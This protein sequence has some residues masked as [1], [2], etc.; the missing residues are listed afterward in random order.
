MAPLTVF[1]ATRLC[2][3]GTVVC[4]EAYKG[5]NDRSFDT[6]AMEATTADVPEIENKVQH[7]VLLILI[8]LL[9][10]SVG[11]IIGIS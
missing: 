11:V 3:N 6:A 10:Y 1:K 2:S 4:I 7:A 9:F 8:V 5:E